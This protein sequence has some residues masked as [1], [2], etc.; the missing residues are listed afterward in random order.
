[1]FEGGNFCVIEYGID[2]AVKRA[3]VIKDIIAKN[4]G[5]VVDT[6]KGKA[7]LIFSRKGKSRLLYYFE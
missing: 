4:G 3:G 1:M 6:K 5:T 7:F 2:L